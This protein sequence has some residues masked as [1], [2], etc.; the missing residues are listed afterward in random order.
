MHRHV[1]LIYVLFLS[2]LYRIDRMVLFI[3]SLVYT[4]WGNDTISANMAWNHTNTNNNSVISLCMPGPGD[5]AEERAGPALG[6][7]DRRSTAGEGRVRLV[8]CV[9]RSQCT[10]AT[11]GLKIVYFTVILFILKIAY[12]V[13]H[14][15]W[16]ISYDCFFSLFKYSFLKYTHFVFHQSCGH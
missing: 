16:S 14:L 5:R 15:S 10:Y 8:R 12:F 1:H 3:Y 2:T 13:F 4:K 11:L 7:P 9:R 6:V